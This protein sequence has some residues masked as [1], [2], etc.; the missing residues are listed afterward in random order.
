MKHD[1][2]DVK[3]GLEQKDRKTLADILH[4]LLATSY[5]LY[6]K[7]QNFHWNV[8]GISFVSLHLLF[9]EHYE[10]LAK[11]I[12]EMAERIRA[13]GFFPQGSFFYFSKL[14]LIKEVTDLLGPI[15]MLEVL[16]EDHQ[17]LICFLREKLPIA[18]K[19]KDGATADFINKRL[20]VHEKTLWMLRSLLTQ[21]GTVE[22]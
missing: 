9:Q 4:V 19:L 20:F 14:S 21:I 8:T 6:L 2:L 5:L 11:T 17:T 18:E 10:E 1:I 12:D 7:T 13:L 22:S 16:A 3:T 15:K